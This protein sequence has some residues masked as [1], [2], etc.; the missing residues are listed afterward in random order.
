MGSADSERPGP[1][2]Q[3]LSFATRLTTAQAPSSEHDV[4]VSAL[5]DAELDRSEEV[6]DSVSYALVQFG[7][8]QPPKTPTSEP[9]RP[10]RAYC[11]R[12]HG[13]TGAHLVEPGSTA[14]TTS[15]SG[16]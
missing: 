7:V 4:V 14:Q 1:P 8:G 5:R 10:M 9:G 2:L 16:E 15:R 3:L 6:R 13:A 12:R 11:A